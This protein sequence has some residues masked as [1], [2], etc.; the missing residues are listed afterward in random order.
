MPATATKVICEET[1]VPGIGGPRLF[2]RVYHPAPG[3]PLRGSVLFLHGYDDHSGRYADTSAMLAD[4]GYRVRTFDFRGHGKSA[5][6]RGFCRKWTEYLDDLAAVRAA[7]D[8]GDAGGKP[9]LVAQSH[10]CLVALHWALKNPGT[11]AGLVLC[12]PYLRLVMPVSRLKIAAAKALNRL[13][14]AMRMKSEIRVDYLTRDPRLQQETL[15]DRTLSR[16]ATPRWFCASTRAQAEIL[17]RAGEIQHPT[18][19]LHGTADRIADLKAARELFET[20]AS[21]DK[22]FKPYESMRHETL[23]EVDR[24]QVWSDIV[25]WLN[26]HTTPR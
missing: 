7:D 9:F 18:L 20:L 13:A 6:K 23:R 12:S 26:A 4:A 17:W 21:K 11:V 1:E 24:E 19:I 8:S 22:T 2:V 15:D 10:G 3:Q 14:P 16:V 25:S 5:G